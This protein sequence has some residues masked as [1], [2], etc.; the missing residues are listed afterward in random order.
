M[1]GSNLDE[2]DHHDDDREQDVSADGEQWWSGSQV[3]ADPGA[4]EQGQGQQGTDTVTDV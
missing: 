1:S 2:L 4:V 3:G